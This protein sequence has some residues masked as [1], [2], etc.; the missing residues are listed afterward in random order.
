MDDGC[1]SGSS[2]G[3]VEPKDL[4]LEQ[5]YCVNAG[6]SGCG[7]LAWTGPKG[8]YCLMCAMVQEWKF[9]SKDGLSIL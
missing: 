9:Q 5:K 3:V 8:A 7:G 1:V 6:R 4:E 2:G